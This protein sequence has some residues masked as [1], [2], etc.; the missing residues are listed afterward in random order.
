MGEKTPTFDGSK[1]LGERLYLAE[2]EAFEWSG[3]PPFAKLDA[4]LQ[5]GYDRA[6]LSFVA[7][8]SDASKDQTH[9]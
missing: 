3:D 6:A 2:I 7:R 5:A 1:S 8:L 4:D 9:G